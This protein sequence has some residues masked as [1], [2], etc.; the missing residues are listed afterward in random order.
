[1]LDLITQVRNLALEAE[2]KG[3][4]GLAE[5]L[6][7]AADE[8]EA[9]AWPEEAER[10]VAHPTDAARGDHEAPDAQPK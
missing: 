8:T 4:K 3:Q 6:R 5:R 7:A 2:L 9:V 10:Y 1:V